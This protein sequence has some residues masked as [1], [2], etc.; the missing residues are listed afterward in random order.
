M[1]SRRY[2]RYRGVCP[3]PGPG[4]AI[5]GHDRVDEFLVVPCVVWFVTIQGV[6]LRHGLAAELPSVPRDAKLTRPVN[7]RYPTIERAD[8]LAQR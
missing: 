6:D 8:K 3:A 1:A 7:V 5:V 2:G 4:T